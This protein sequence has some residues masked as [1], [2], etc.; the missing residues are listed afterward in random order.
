MYEQI[1][2]TNIPFFTMAW[3]FFKWLLKSKNVLLTHCKTC[4]TLKHVNAPVGNQNVQSRWID[5]Q[6]GGNGIL[7][8]NVFHIECTCKGSIS[9]LMWST[10][11]REWSFFAMKVSCTLTLQGTLLLWEPSITVFVCEK[12]KHMTKVCNLIEPN[13]QILRLYTG[14]HWLTI[15]YG[16]VR[17]PTWIWSPSRGACLFAN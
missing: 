12:K 3:G 1:C 11:L 7:S 15:V 2:I 13:V 10:F 4:N 14:Y 6:H 17:K 16:F 8:G 5:S 9:R